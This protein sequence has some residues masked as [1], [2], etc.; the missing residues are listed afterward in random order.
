M[1]STKTVRQP[2]HAKKGNQGRPSSFEAGTHKDLE[3]EAI[4]ASPDSGPVAHGSEPTVGNAHIFLPALVTKS[5][6]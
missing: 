3:Q 4:F 1:Y 2:E 6:H 5:D